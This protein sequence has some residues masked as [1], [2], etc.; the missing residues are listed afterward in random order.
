VQRAG[1]EFT[2]EG[3]PGLPQTKFDFETKNLQHT[4][5]DTDFMEQLRKQTIMAHSL[6]PEV[7]DSGF[8]AEFATT[9]VA[10]NILLSKRV[11]Q[12]QEKFTP[13]LTDFARK[14]LQHDEEST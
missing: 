11:L 12:I 5:P 7:V 4:V 3:H 6:S 14:L 10:N 8:S 13:Q 2:F 1:F 9:V